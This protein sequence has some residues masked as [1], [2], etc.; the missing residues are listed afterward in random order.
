MATRAYQAYRDVTIVGPTRAIATRAFNS[1]L[2]MW[3]G[4]S[5]TITTRAY[6][7]MVK[8]YFLAFFKPQNA[9]PCKVAAL[10]VWFYK[11]CNTWYI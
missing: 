8:W 4:P 5:Q 7:Q 1:T 6:Y 2:K 9:H 10:F 11:K 3:L